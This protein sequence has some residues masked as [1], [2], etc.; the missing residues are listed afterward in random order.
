MGEKEVNRAF[1]GDAE[2]D[3][4]LSNSIFGERYCTELR[5]IDKHEIIVRICDILGSNPSNLHLA[6][7]VFEKL[8]FEIARYIIHHEYCRCNSIRSQL[9]LWLD[10][11]INPDNAKKLSN[12]MKKYLK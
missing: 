12:F 5:E 1:I 2:D 9:L 6:E 7:D 4:F 3:V 10:S 8:K 11:R